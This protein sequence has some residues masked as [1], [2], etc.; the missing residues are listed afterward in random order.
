M[1]FILS[2]LNGTKTFLPRKGG[3]FIPG[4]LDEVTAT[5]DLTAWIWNELTGRI[6][7]LSFGHSPCTGL[8]INISSHQDQAR[9]RYR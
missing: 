4:V 5:R 9:R 8:Q 1:K 3:Y 2:F 6:S 7:D